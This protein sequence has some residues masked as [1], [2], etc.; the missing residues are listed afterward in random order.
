M[1]ATLLQRR[2]F[3]RALVLTLLVLGAVLASAPP[4]LASGPTTLGR[5]GWQVVRPY[6]PVSTLPFTAPLGDHGFY[7]YIPG[8]IPGASDAGWSD[9]GPANGLCASAD[10][11]D[12]YMPNGS[13]LRGYVCG[14]SA[15]F[16]SSRAR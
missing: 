7:N 12:M 9:C 14:G 8:P 16:P 2:A 11:V 6:G 10:T 15:D 13:R 3:A 1:R 4:V 5:T